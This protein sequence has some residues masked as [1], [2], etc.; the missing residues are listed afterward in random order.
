MMK[1]PLFLEGIS[2]CPAKQF[3][4]MFFIMSSIP[5]MKKLR[6]SE[7]KKLAVMLH[8]AGE[9]ELPKD[10]YL[11]IPNDFLCIPGAQ[12]I[13]EGPLKD[14]HFPEAEPSKSKK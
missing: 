9:I 2:M 14:C 11:M 5:K 6:L 4:R 1:L 10:P 7:A 8:V 12:I 3:T 13:Y